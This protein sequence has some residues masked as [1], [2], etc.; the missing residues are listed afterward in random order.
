MLL[1]LA[2][3][4]S[5]ALTDP[6]QN[7]VAVVGDKVTIKCRSNLTVDNIVWRYTNTMG[8]LQPT[9]F[10]EG[11]NPNLA[12]RNVTFET[13][14][15]IFQSVVLSDAGTYSCQDSVGY[16]PAA[17]LNVL[18]KPVCMNVTTL[19]NITELTCSLQYNG[20]TSK[21]PGYL[22]PVAKWS[23]LPSSFL[24]GDSQTNLTVLD[25]SS[26]T[27]TLKQLTTR[28]ELSSPAV[29]CVL[30]VSFQR[31]S[32]DANFDSRQPTYLFTYQY[33]GAGA[34]P[35]PTANPSTSS[36]A[37][38]H[39]IGREGDNASSA[40]TASTP[41]VIAVVVVVLV[42]VV[43]VAIVVVFVG[44]YRRGRKPAAD[45]QRYTTTSCPFIY[46]H[47]RC[48]EWEARSRI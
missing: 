27:P 20:S 29:D 30:N 36:A 21:S 11:P 5:A 45:Q 9:L 13:Y 37:T 32:G 46:R 43:V 38:A 42:V 14:D 19:L 44:R 48:D 24:V 3:Q 40:A 18:E 35:T 33:T 23:C 16:Q 2:D 12:A 31:V 10:Q 41:A 1:T 22:E 6:P 7:T 26:S 28:V 8:V 34:L 47:V 25:L 4:T 17:A 39:D 15:M